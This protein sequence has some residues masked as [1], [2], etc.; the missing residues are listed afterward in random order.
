MAERCVPQGF[1]SA[2]TPAGP[3][4]GQGVYLGNIPGSSNTF[5]YRTNGYS[6]GEADAVRFGVTIQTDTGFI[7][8]FTNQPNNVF[9]M[10][11]AGGVGYIQGENI[12]FS[13]PYS[14]VA[15]A[16]ILPK[17]GVMNIANL[18]FVSTVSAGPGTGTVNMIELISTIKGNNWAQVL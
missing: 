11:T 18:N 5:P 3:Q 9:R 7:S 12:R 14:G 17:E 4:M 10:I 15:G 6:G 8:S 16:A 13:A 1:V 2:G